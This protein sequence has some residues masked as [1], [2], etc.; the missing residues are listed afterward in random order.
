MTLLIFLSFPEQLEVVGPGGPPDGHGKGDKIWFW[1]NNFI[2]M[3]GPLQNHSQGNIPSW[4]T[5][6]PAASFAI[7]GAWNW[8]MFSDFISPDGLAALASIKPPDANA[9]SDSIVWKLFSSSDF[10]LKTAYNHLMGISDI[11]HIADH[12]FKKI[13]SWQGP[14][15]ISSFIWKLYHGRLLTNSERMKRGTPWNFVFPIA[16]C[17]ARRVISSIAAPWPISQRIYKNEVLINWTCPPKGFYKLN[18]DGYVG[19]NSSTASCEGLLRDDNGDFVEGFVCNLGISSTLQAELWG[20]LHGL[21]MAEKKRI[22]NLIVNT[23]SKTSVQLINN[24][25][26]NTHHCFILINRIRKILL[27]NPS[28]FLCHTFRESNRAAD[29][30][31]FLGHSEC[32]GVHSL[33]IPPPPLIPILCQDSRGVSF[34]RFVRLG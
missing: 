8:N 14:P 2:P 13:W 11:N 34:S 6:L 25:V 19:N 31:A 3:L 27:E 18:I 7:N 20:I 26:P 17:Y 32:L 24:R 5:D 15:R 21:K 16:A 29:H 33:L 10:S 4:Q 9:D 22:V 28:F 30:L 12:V 23:D 1:K